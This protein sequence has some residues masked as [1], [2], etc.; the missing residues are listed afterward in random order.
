MAPAS[1]VKIAVS[2]SVLAAAS[3]AALVFGVNRQASLE[4]GSVAATTSPPQPALS[5]GK[6]GSSAPPAAAETKQIKQAEETRQADQIKQ[7]D[8]V[9]QIGET[10]GIRDARQATAAIAELAGQA[11]IA[12]TDQSA[13]S[14]DLARIEENGDAVVAGRAA[15]G[16]VVEL[17]RDDERLDR[18]VADPSG[19]FV[20]VSRLPAGSYELTLSA[21]LPDGTLARSKKGVMVAVKTAGAAASVAQSRAEYIPESAPQAR[22][23][24]QPP[25]QA[26]KPQQSA[27]LKPT[28]INPGHSASEE[29]VASPTLAHRSVARVAS[30]DSLWRISRIV[31]GDGAR[32]AIVYRAN[33]DRIQDPN[34]I[35]PGQILVLPVKHH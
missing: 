30:G 13:P 35:H 4:T 9:K 25:L 2:V 34:L 18:V 14:F 1:I 5:V 23:S 7:T 17:L 15:P 10:K 29:S 8:E 33:R 24:M 12:A 19:D 31:Y 26:S 16:A 20:M 27:D 28:P 21:R 22:L 3:G 11:D 6:E 32:Y